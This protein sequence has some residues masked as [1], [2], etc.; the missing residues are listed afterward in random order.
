MGMTIDNIVDS[1]SYNGDV[2]EVQGVLDNW[3]MEKTFQFITYDNNNPGD[4]VINGTDWNANNW[5]S[6]GGMMLMCHAS[7]T[8]S[9]WHGFASND[10]EWV[11]N[12]D[13]STLCTNE[14]GFIPA[15]LQKN[16][17]FIDGLFKNG[18]NKVWA[19]SPTVSLRGTPKV[20]VEVSCSMTIDNIV[21]SVSYN[22]DV[23]EVQGVLDN[24]EMEKT[25]QFI[26]YDNNNPGDLVINGTDWNANNWCSNGGM[27]LMCH[28]SDTTSPWHGFASNDKEWV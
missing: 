20:P 13:N 4:L 15:A 25:F 5:C 18:A 17:A 1:V 27:I 2:L 3:E 23:L 24:W 14:D 21:D 7:D 12:V 26:T 19:D 28:A 10:K 22:G 16:I 8:T 11:N 9:P 6:N